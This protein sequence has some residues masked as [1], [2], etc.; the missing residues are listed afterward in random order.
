MN[1]KE[2][3]EL[4]KGKISYEQAIKRFDELFKNDFEIP[5]EFEEEAQF[6]RVI[7]SKIMKNKSGWY[8][9]NGE[10]IYLLDSDHGIDGYE[11][12]INIKYI[13]VKNLESLEK[14]FT[15]KNYEVEWGE[16]QYIDWFKE[17]K[18]VNVEIKIKK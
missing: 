4:R 14:D 7:I 16:I 13:P 18:K 2:K 17:L 10:L 8:L 11:E 12:L 3:E 5:K 9:Y 1:K 15:D 6:L